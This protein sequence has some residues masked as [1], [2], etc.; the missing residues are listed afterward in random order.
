MPDGAWRALAAGSGASAE[1]AFDPVAFIDN[2]YTDTQVGPPPS[3]GAS[4]LK[5]IIRSVLEKGIR[6]CH[7]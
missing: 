3:G 4:G 5:I 6:R 7:F 2:E 1:E